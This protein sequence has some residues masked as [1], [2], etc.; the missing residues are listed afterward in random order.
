MWAAETLENRVIA[1]NDLRL[2]ILVPKF[3]AWGPKSHFHQKDL[4]CMRLRVLECLVRSTA[5]DGEVEE[6]YE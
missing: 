3:W 1:E 6:V 4:S 5:P 2:G